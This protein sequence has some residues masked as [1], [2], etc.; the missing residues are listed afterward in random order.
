MHFRRILHRD[1]K[2]ANVF[3]N[4]AGIVKLGDLG[5]SRLFSAKT[6]HAKTRVGTE[7]Y[8]AP[9]RT[10]GSGY[11][12]KSD[13]WSL[14]CLLYEMCTLRS[15]FNGETTNAYALHKRVSQG[16]FPPFPMGKYSRQVSNFFLNFY[17]IIILANILYNQLPLC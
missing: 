11:H 8:M 2:P 12:F 14:G 15:P 6:M 10:S 9:E 13:I 16:D 4:S 3:L 7:Y 17:N 5:L 1:L